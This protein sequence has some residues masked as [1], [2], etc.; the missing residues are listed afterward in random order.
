MMI[1]LIIGAIIMAYTY[2]VWNKK[3]EI[4]KR[5]KSLNYKI[6]EIKAIIAHLLLSKRS[7]EVE[8][9]DVE[10]LL[11]NLK[12]H[13]DLTYKIKEG[14]LGVLI[15]KEFHEFDVENKRLDIFDLDGI[16]ST[17]LNQTQNKENVTKEIIRMQFNVINGNQVD[18]MRYSEE[19]LVLIEFVFS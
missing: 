8:V 6:A 11:L 2:Y 19:D 9:F 15:G 14:K 16:I 3:K 4:E 12:H 5:E 17:V 13:V 10:E 1:K 18:R 7:G